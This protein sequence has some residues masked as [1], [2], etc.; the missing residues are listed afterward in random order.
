MTVAK[1]AI[2]QAEDTLYRRGMLWYFQVFQH[3]FRHSDIQTFRH[4]DIGRKRNKRS[5]MMNYVLKTLAVR[6]LIE[7]Y[8][9]EVKREEEKEASSGKGRKMGSMDYFYWLIVS[10]NFWLSLSWPQTNNV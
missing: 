4:S 5:K 1:F 7:A 9:Q 10:P 2:L 6:R 8:G 3:V